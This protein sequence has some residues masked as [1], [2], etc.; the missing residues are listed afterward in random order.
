M[1][2]KIELNKRGL[3]PRDVFFLLRDFRNFGWS[4]RSFYFHL[5]SNFARTEK[6]KE[7]KDEIK[8]VLFHYDD[9]LNKLKSC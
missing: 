1:D 9:F 4:E 3:K 2:V 8:T 7:I 6:D 5:E